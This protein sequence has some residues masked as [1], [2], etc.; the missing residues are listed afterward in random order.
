MTIKKYGMVP[1]LAL[2]FAV[3]MAGSASAQTPGVT[4]K[5][6]K[7]GNINPYSGPLPLTARSASRSPP[8]SRW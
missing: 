4:D 8:T 1:A 6:I 7:I 5:E 2:G 3:A